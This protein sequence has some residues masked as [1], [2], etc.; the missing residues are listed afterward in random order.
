MGGMEPKKVFIVTSGCYS[1]YGISSVYSTRE[2]AEKAIGD[3]KDNDGY[4]SRIEEYVLDPDDRHREGYKSYVVTMLRDGTTE[5]IEEDD[6]FYGQTS[7]E[8]WERSKCTNPKADC[9]SVQVAV[10]RKEHAVKI[11]NEKRAALIATNQ[12]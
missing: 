11:A 10:R 4:G 6:F 8:I 7:C 3:D 12:W 1:D 2:A 5:E 9:L